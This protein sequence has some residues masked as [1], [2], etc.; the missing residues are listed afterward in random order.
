M[1]RTS[2]PRRSNVHVAGRMGVLSLLA[3][4]V[5]SSVFAM[6]AQ[7]G[8]TAQQKR[9]LCF[10]AGSTTTRVSHDARAYTI[11]ARSGDTRLRAC[12]FST[13]RS[14]TLATY[15]EVLS[16]ASARALAGR[17][18]AWDHSTTP[19]C[20]GQCPPGFVPRQSLNVTNLRTGR[21]RSVETSAAKVG[22]TT[23]GALVWLRSDGAAGATIR[24]LD[25]RGQRTIDSGDVDKRFL[26][27]FST[28]VLWRKGGQNHWVDLAG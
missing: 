5:L 2:D 24:V 7:A 25:A 3:A 4:F 23:G 17:Y 19:G 6:A 16:F 9:R 26:K 20:R 12:L 10:P 15:D 27:V 1:H 22:V 18:V 21:T 14:R 13:G 11:D 8:L 28:F